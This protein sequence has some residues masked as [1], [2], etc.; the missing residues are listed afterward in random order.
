MMKVDCPNFGRNL[1]CYTADRVVS[2]GDA[3]PMRSGAQ[4]EKSSDNS[5]KTPLRKGTKKGPYTNPL[6]RK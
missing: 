5:A 1:S 6:C 2:R 4:V 3:T